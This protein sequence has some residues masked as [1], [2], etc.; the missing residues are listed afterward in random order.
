MNSENK[1]WF[2]GKTALVL[3]AAAVGIALFIYFKKKNKE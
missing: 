2:T 3:V 1:S